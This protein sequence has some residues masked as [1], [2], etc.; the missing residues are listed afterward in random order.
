MKYTLISTKRFRKDLESLERQ[1]AE[2]VARK[3]K[4]Y[5]LFNVHNLKKSLSGV[6]DK[7]DRKL[8]IYRIGDMRVIF[9]ID[10]QQEKVR[11]ITVGY[12]GNV[13]EEL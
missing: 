9:S 7:F 6:T 2:R 3:L 12:R 13:Y 5:F 1:N 8:Y 11:L 10:D 4:N